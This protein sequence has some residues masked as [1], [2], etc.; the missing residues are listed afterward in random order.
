M[1][2]LLHTRMC[3]GIYIG[4][5][6]KKKKRIFKAIQTYMYCIHLYKQNVQL[7]TRAKNLMS[8]YLQYFLGKNANVRISIRRDILDEVVQM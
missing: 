6:K 8:K 4:I 3:V 7:D 1:Y 5:K 2:I